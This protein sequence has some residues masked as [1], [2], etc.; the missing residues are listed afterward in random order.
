MGLNL[1]NTGRPTMVRC[2][3]VRS[4]VAGFVALYRV[5]RQPGTNVPG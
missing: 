4:T 2:A 5:I 1:Y 3:Q